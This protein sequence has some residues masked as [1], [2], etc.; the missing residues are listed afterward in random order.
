V[1]DLALEKRY[2]IAYIISSILLSLIIPSTAYWIT[3]MMEQFVVAVK[4][5]Q[6]IGSKIVLGDR[7][8]DVTLKR[9]TEALVQTDLK[10]LF[11]ESSELEQNMKKFLP[12]SIRDIPND[13]S[14]SKDQLSEYVETLK[15][16]ENVKMIMANLKL[17]A[18][19]LYNA[20]VSERDEFMSQGLISLNQY[21]SIVAVMG[22]AHIDGVENRLIRQGWTK[23]EV[24]CPVG[25]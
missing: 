5:G 1:K 6:A 24:S 25:L 15:A 11:S 16:K 22:V 9:L 12:E 10:K 7:D 19:E 8:V 18:P 21:R 14:L 13:A 20:M 17:I 4:A 23:I 3:M 2:E